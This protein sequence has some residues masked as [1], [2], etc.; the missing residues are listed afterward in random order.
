MPLPWGILD[1]AYTRILESYRPRLLESRGVLFQTEP[2]DGNAV[3][4]GFDDSQGWNNLF[5]RGLEIVPVI[6]DHISMVHQHGQMLARQINEVL[7]RHWSNQDNKVSIDAHE[8][9][10]APRAPQP[11]AI[12][13]VV[14]PDR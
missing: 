12:A 3:L 6:G 5:S 2:I 14:C 8:R 1:R 9:Q 11:G 4:R 13:S 7:Q 10:R